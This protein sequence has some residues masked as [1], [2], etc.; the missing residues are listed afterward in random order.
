MTRKL[1][2]SNLKDKDPSFLSELRIKNVNRL[3]IGNLNIN[4]IFKKFG[5]LKATV[6]STPDILLIT[7]AK[8]ERK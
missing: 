5:Q 2:N 3:I 4:S 6:E 8:L 7:E 1:K